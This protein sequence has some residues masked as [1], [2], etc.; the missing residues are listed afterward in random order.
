M[1]WAIINTTFKKDY[2]TGIIESD[3]KGYYAYLP[4]VFIYHD[5][6]FGFYNDIEIKTYYNPNLSL[7]YE[8]FRL[9]E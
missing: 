7:D 6:N 8:D 4:A 5:L 9:K 1:L 3:A 2:K